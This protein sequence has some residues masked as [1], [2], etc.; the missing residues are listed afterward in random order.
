MLMRDRLFYSFGIAR[1]GATVLWG[2]EF[3][4]ASGMVTLSRISTWDNIIAACNE[5]LWA[6]SPKRYDARS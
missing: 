1:M 2:V 6:M 5:M 4:T 3:F